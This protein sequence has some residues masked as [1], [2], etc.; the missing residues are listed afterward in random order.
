MANARIGNLLR[1]RQI[2]KV[3]VVVNGCNN[4]REYGRPKIQSGRD[5]TIPSDMKEHCESRVAQKKQP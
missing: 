5:N 1:V 4:Q 2:V 3:T